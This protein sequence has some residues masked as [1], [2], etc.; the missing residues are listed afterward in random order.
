MDKKN[1]TI[2]H[3]FYKRFVM[4]IKVFAFKSSIRY[5]PTY[6]SLSP[7]FTEINKIL[8]DMANKIGLSATYIPAI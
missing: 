1:I 5:T 3:F 2:S 8:G 4:H 7:L 6:I